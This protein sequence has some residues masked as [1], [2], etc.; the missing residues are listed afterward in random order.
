ML[1][2]S[3]IQT[4]QRIMITVQLSRLHSLITF[5]DIN[6]VSICLCLVGRCSRSAVYRTREMAARALVPFVLVTQV[7]CTVRTLLQELPPESGPNIQHNHIHG[8]LL[9]VC[10]HTRHINQYSQYA[11]HMPWQSTVAGITS[12]PKIPQECHSVLL[13]CMLYF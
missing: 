7:P 9:Q 3:F 4:T 10:N 13:D 8:T 12:P 5:H 2:C 6:L 1:L 11:Q